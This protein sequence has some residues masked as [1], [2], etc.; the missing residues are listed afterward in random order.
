MTSM[1]AIGA[2]ILTGLAATG[3]SA[4]DLV[5]TNAHIVDPAGRTVVEGGIWIVDG[6]VAGVGQV[7]ADARAPG[8]AGSRP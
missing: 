5:L 6:K 8:N 7:P 1:K 4:Q 2:L 3:A